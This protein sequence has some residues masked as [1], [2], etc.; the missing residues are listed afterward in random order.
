MPCTPFPPS[1]LQ[2]RGPAPTGKIRNLTPNCC[3]PPPTHPNYGFLF[4]K[5]EIF[6]F[7]PD[8]REIF[9]RFSRNLSQK[10]KFSRKFLH[11]EKFA[12]RNFVKLKNGFSFQ[13][14][15]WIREPRGT[16]ERKNRGWKSCETV[17]LSVTLNTGMPD[18]PASCQSG[19]GIKLTMPYTVRYRNKMTQSGTFSPC[20]G[21]GGRMPERQC[22]R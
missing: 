7:L 2:L 9:V 6:R 12:E 15:S 13:P 17:P 11:N 4:T 21:L 19:T 22:R 8:F 16:V 1:F 18:C 14:Y 3:P 20:T 10:Q 5:K